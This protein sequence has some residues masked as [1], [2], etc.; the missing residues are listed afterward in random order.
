M[1]A[2]ETSQIFDIID[3]LGQKSLTHLFKEWVDV[4]LCLPNALLSPVVEWTRAFA[5]LGPD[6]LVLL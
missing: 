4:K 6:V 1:L 3:R 2:T 5:L